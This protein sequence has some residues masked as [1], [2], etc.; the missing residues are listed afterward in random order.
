MFVDTFEGQYHQ[1]KVFYIT[2][3][4]KKIFFFLNFIKTV[5]CFHISRD[6]EGFPF[7]ESHI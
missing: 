5:S 1:M 2:F 4:I 7:F 6:G 3:F